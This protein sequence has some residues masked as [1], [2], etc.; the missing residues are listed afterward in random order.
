MPAILVTIILPVLL[1][2][3]W[4][5]YNRD[6]QLRKADYVMRY[7]V[8]A[9]LI[10]LGSSV[11][12]TVT[13]DDDTSFWIKI[14]Q[15]TEFS[16]KYICL[17]MA[18]A[19]ALA[20]MEWLC[21][22]QK[23]RLDRI[24]QKCGLKT[25]GPKV[26]AKVV[27]T[28]LL[29]VLLSVKAVDYA[30]YRAE[31]KEQE[32]L[33][34]H[35][36]E[37]IGEPEKNIPLVTNGVE[38]PG[39]SILSRHYP[40]NERITGDYQSTDAE[41]FWYL[42]ADAFSDKEKELLET[43]GYSIVDHGEQQLAACPFYLYYMEKEEAEP[44]IVTQ[45]GPRDVNSSFY[46]IY[47]AKKGLIVIDGGWTEDAMAVKD[48]IKSQS[49]V[50]DAWILTHPHQD[51]IG[52]FNE[53]YAELQEDASPDI[54]VEDIYTVDMAPPEECLEV[55]SWDSVDTYQDFLELEIPD[56]NYVYPG[57]ELDICGLKFNIYNAYDENVEELSRDYIND[58]SMMFE[59]TAD[60]DSFLFCADVGRSMSDYLLEKW[61]EE[62]QADYVQMGHH[63]YG[64]P[65]DD[66]YE[67]VA[68]SVAFFDA[69][70]WMMYD[71]TG[72][73]DNLQHISLMENMGSE[74][75]SFNSAPNFV[76]LE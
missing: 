69:P 21:T 54:Q 70:D 75:L 45:Y 5:V 40:E 66:F 63:G 17:V 8:Y 18:V 67:M 42:S 65:D 37:I 23:S 39:V 43:A 25:P 76:I 57:D 60:T 41:N 71:I 72:K 13:R 19:I 58:G 1:I 31:R 46:T 64:G 9:L 11:L 49:G 59:V 61:G 52:A 62:L 73:Y 29:F 16:V 27:I 68:P 4:R 74:V 36:L 12:L 14:T 26:L 35:T 56:L 38:D 50:V 44:W 32:R 7:F 6:A 51:H 48:I 24:L 10:V 22:K 28:C 53:I 47:N 33:T 30:E 34:A 15:S 55:A 3:V 2:L 20:G